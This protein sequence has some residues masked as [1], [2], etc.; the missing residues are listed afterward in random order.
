MVKNRLKT[1]M[2]A[3]V[4]AA[5]LSTSAAAGVVTAPNIDLIEISG[6][7]ELKFIQAKQDSATGTKTNNY[8]TA[9]INLNLDAS[10]ENGL[11]VYT[12]FTA[13]DDTQATATQNTDVRTKVAYAQL[14]VLG[15]GKV[16]AGLVPNFQYGTEAFDMGGEAWK[17]AVFMPVAKG[18]KVGLISKIEN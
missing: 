16:L 4:A 9:E 3:A 6:D 13:F 17:A 15:K 5:G 2:A 1:S 10:F 12:T 14:P 8:R 18:V 11:K 7:A